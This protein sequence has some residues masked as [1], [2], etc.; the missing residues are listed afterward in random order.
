[1]YKN[2]LLRPILIVGLITVLF[3]SCDKDFD[4][5]G[6]NIVGD[7]HFGFDLDTTSVTVRSF[8]Q[9]LGAI[10]SNNLPINPLGFYNNPAFGETQANFVTQVAMDA[11]SVN[12]TFNNDNV[13]TPG[14]Y[15][16]APVVDSVILNI[17][18]F[19]T[20]KATDS[21]GK[22]TYELD[23][24]YPSDNQSKFK[25]SIYQS[26]YYLRDLDPEQGLA[27]QQLF[28]TNQDAEIDANKVNT[29]LNDTIA[30]AENSQFFFDYREQVTTK[31]DTEG[32][33]VIPT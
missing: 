16:I 26:K 25:L 24:I 28:Y 10:S 3:A 6:T 29:L 17:P 23:S 31:F 11:S 4:E 5:L 30:S 32:T 18:Y 7:D 8:N 15:Q 12:R 21:N 14:S 2:S 19:K 20:L 9:P 33:T 1:M 27:E 13:T 22:S